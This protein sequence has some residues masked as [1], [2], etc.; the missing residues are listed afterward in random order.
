MPFDQRSLIHREAWFPPCFLGQRIPQNP[1]FFEKWKKSS[2]TQKLKNHLEICQNQRYALRPEVSNPSGSVVSGWTKNTQ[3]QNFFEQRKKSSKTQ[4]LKNVQRYA[5]I[6][7]TPF[8]QRSLIH[9][10]AWFP[11]CFVRQKQ[12][13]KNFFFARRFQT[14]FKQKCSNVRPLLT[15]T[16]PQGFRISKNIG[17]RNL[18]RGG[19]KTF[20]RYLKSEQTDGQTDKQTDIST[21]R[22]HRPRGP[23]L[24]KISTFFS[25]LC[26]ESWEAFIY[27]HFP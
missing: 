7:N 22:K 2:K 16:F 19:K 21:Y 11:P 26:A 20:K 4:K 18:G 23:M 1:I 6:S 5:K 25:Y 27:Y 8:D 13:Q 14:T 10:E 12:Q 9:R 3:K 15:I 17:H 24:C